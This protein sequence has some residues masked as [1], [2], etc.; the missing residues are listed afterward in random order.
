M[1]G[2]A[3]VRANSHAG[4]QRFAFPH[5]SAS[6]QLVRTPNTKAAIRE[7]LGKREYQVIF[8]SDQKLDY[9]QVNGNYIF[10][11]T[12]VD[13]IATMLETVSANKWTLIDLSMRESALEEIYVKLMTNE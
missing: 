2:G 10:R 4:M 6:H 7:R 5:I 8:H 11:T 3:A 13:A 9:E 1:A 12:E